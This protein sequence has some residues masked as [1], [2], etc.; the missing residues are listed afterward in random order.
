[1][2][3]YLSERAKWWPV[4]P[5]LMAEYNDG[6]HTNKT[7][8]GTLVWF[9]NG[10]YHRDGDK[11]AYIGSDGS[12]AWFKN[13]VYHRD[14]DKPAVIWS[15]GGLVWVKNGHGHR[16]TGPT[17]IRPNKKKEYYINGVNITN[18]VK[19]WLKTRKYNAPVTPEQQVEFVLTFS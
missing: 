9:K 8:G 3:K 17:V 2:E 13:G 1:M 14:G 6:S 16:T 15:D 12:L 4:S 10:V 19:S 7:A 11:P 18:E 5:E